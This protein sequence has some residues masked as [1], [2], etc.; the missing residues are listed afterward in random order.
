MDFSSMLQRGQFAALS[1]IS[2]LTVITYWPNNSWLNLPVFDVCFL[3]LVLLYLASL[4]YPCVQA[5]QLKAR[6]WL[7]L[8]FAAWLLLNSFIVGSNSAALPIIQMLVVLFV[9]TH[10]NFSL[11]QIRM[12]IY[13]LVLAGSLAALYGIVQHFLMPWDGFVSTLGNAN[14]V[15][16]FLSTLIPVSFSLW[17]SP[18]KGLKLLGVVTTALMVTAMTLTFTRAGWITGLGAMAAVALLKNKK[19]LLAI[20]LFVLVLSL[21]FGG[22]GTRFLQIGQLKGIANL[23]E[24]HPAVKENSFN[25]RINLWRFALKEFR[26]NPVQGIGIGN[27]RNRLADYIRTHPGK[28]K[29]F[30]YG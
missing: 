20:C 6:D 8:P 25:S 16:G 24:N 7:L 13:C 2:L 22:V 28:A 23:A 3:L 19:L 1:L 9:V 27:Y 11:R 18:H 21:S 30:F 4:L 5:P 10:S 14:L 15:S 12:I 17:L 26:E 29:Q